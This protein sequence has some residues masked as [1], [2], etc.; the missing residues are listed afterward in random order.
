MKSRKRGL[1]VV[2]GVVFLLASTNAAAALIQIPQ[3]SLLPDAMTQD[4]STAMVGAISGTDS[5]FT[6][7]GLAS[8]GLL[9]TFVAD[10]DILNSGV[11]GNALV[12]RGNVLTIAA[13]SSSLDNMATGS[14]WQFMV[15][16]TA[17]QFGYRII[18]QL[19]MS[20]TVQTYSGGTLQDTFIYS[21]TGSFPN[22][23]QFFS[24]TAFDEFRV[25]STLGGSGWGLDDVTLAGKS[26][27]P[28]PGTLALLALGLAGFGYARRRRTP[29]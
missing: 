28:E 29:R 17:T 11:F 10:G 26:A 24:D 4:F 22:P 14:G 9:G 12:S 25:F 21:E 5:V 16:G 18:D 20:V 6:S 13:P 1:S 23:Q 7:I 2:A 27:V 19:N 15:A 8:V 3:A